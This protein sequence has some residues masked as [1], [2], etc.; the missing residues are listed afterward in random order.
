MYHEGGSALQQ[1]PSSFSCEE[2]EAGF[3]K[4]MSVLISLLWKRKIRDGAM[5]KALLL[6]LSVTRV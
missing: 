6:W 3:G 1:S 4:E 5:A 2:R